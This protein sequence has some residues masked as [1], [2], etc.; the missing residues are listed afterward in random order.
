M[1]KRTFIYLLLVPFFLQSQE[2]KYS[3]KGIF[4]DLNLASGTPFGQLAERFGSHLSVGSGL[5]Y[6][7]SK[8]LDFGIK[9]QYFFSRNVKED[10]L[11][12]YKTNFGQ[13]IGED[14]LMTDVVLR[15]RGYSI[16]AF[17]GGLIPFGSQSKNRQGIRWMIG[18]GFL[19]HHIRIQDDARAA[20]QLYSD[21]GRGLDR[22]SYGFSAVGFL[23]YELKSMNGRIN[24]YAG[25]ESVFGFTEGR[26]Q[27]NYDLAQSD[28]GKSRNDN[29]I[30]FKIGWYLPFFFKNSDVIE[31]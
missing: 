25:I 15:E 1:F 23:G 19:Q 6:Q 21:F 14:F 13:L 28:F 7:P 17:T 11:E 29:F 22:L 2:N 10:V 4:L 5:G 8:G 27:W 24:F 18:P 30:Q 31:Y 9:F 12:P 3:L 26:R 20:T 16:H